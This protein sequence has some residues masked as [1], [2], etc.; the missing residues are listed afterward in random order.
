[1]SSLW[2]PETEA[3]LVHTSQALPHVLLII[4]CLLLTF[5]HNLLN[6]SDP[7]QDGLL[8]LSRVGVAIYVNEVRRGEKVRGELRLFIHNVV[9]TIPH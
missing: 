1:L 2:S 6:R 5:G 4:L 9:L 8:L 7:L 3:L